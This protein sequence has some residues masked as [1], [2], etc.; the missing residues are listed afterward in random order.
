MC[1]EERSLACALSVE[2]EMNKV[3][4]L[5]HMTRHSVQAST[6]YV[7]PCVVSPPVKAYLVISTTRPTSLK[8]S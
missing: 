5:A 6:P 7:T 3:H 2:E 8:P 1:S 4:A